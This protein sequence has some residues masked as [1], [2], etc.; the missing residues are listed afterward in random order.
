MGESHYSL[1]CAWST[2]P[3]LVL[4]WVQLLLL[5]ILEQ[6]EL[7]SEVLPANARAVFH[8]SASSARPTITCCHTGGT[9]GASLA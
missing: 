7:A 4:L 9:S 8:Y 6:A 2:T 1:V 3:S 5:G